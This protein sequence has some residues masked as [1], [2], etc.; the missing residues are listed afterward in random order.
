MCLLT[1]LCILAP[2][3]ELRGNSQKGARKRDLKNI[4]SYHR[5]EVLRS[6]GRDAKLEA[7]PPQLI[8][9][10]AVDCVDSGHVLDT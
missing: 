2:L 5:D 1:L 6:L 8:S 9:P 10:C 4:I 3:A 7:P